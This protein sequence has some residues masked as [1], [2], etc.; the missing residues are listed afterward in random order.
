M[1]LLLNVFSG[2]V[3]CVAPWACRAGHENWL[4]L[5]RVGVYLRSLID[6]DWLGQA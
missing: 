2:T 1:R 4:F 3:E 5:V 6:R